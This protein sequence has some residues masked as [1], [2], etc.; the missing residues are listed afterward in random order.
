M[1]IFC[2]LH[3]PLSHEIGSK[4]KNFC[5]ESSHVTYQIKGY[6]AE[7]TTQANILSLLSHSTLWWGL[8]VKISLFCVST[9]QCHVVVCGLFRW[10]LLVIYTY[11]LTLKNKFENIQSGERVSNDK[12]NGSNEHRQDEP[13]SC[14]NMFRIANYWYIYWLYW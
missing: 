4:G 6:R 12:C 2:L 5:F 8:E 14:S 3:T 1:H 13:C 10:H 7:S 9:S 11:G